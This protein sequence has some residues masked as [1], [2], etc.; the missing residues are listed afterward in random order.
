MEYRIYFTDPLDRG[1]GYIPVLKRN[2]R[3]AIKTAERIAVKRPFELWAGRRLVFR[4]GVRIS[5]DKAI[6]KRCSEFSLR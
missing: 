1:M 2:D 4:Y 5:S 3:A 6:S